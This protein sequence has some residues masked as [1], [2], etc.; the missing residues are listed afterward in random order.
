MNSEAD[1]IARARAMGRYFL[2]NGCYPLFMVWKS[3]MLEAFADILQDTIQPRATQPGMAGNWLTD[4]MSDP[5]LEKTVGRGVAKPLWSEMKE[6]AM[7]AAQPGRGADL[8][9]N[10]I[11]SLA[12]TWGARFELHLVGHSA[13][14]IMLGKLL[15]NL[16]QKGLLDAVK[17]CHLYAPACSIGFANR[18]YASHP[19]IMQNLYIDILSDKRERED[20][21]AHVYQK[22]LL[23]FV[24]NALEADARTPILGMTNVLDPNYTGWDGAA[25][26]SESLELWRQAVRNSKLKNRITIHSEQEFVT[27]QARN[28]VKEQVEKASHGGFDNNVEV[29]SQTL[30][31]IVAGKLTLPI[32]DLVG[33]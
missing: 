22:S 3:G 30:Q 10:A 23:Y 21:V 27:R 4:N 11:R 25:V 12:G 8:L 26:T 28:G 13:G 2:Q 20:H 24:S 6:N 16:A 9:S 1:A 17:S 32:D 14:S 15:G 18:E 29:L 33:F 19:G 5:V 7:L 31:R